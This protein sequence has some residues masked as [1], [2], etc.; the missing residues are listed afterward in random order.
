MKILIR[1]MLVGRKAAPTAI[2]RTFA[3]V[4]DENQASLLRTFLFE[5][6]SKGKAAALRPGGRMILE[7]PCRNCFA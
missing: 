7:K 1:E 5:P 2:S 6:L 4:V 3:P